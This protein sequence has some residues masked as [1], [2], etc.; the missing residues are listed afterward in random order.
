ML[1]KFKLHGGHSI[2]YA[3]YMLLPRKH[4]RNISSLSRHYSCN[5]GT[6]AYVSVMLCHTRFFGGWFYSAGDI[7]L[8]FVAFPLTWYKHNR[9]KMKKLNGDALPRNEIWLSRFSPD[10]GEK[11][12]NNADN[13]KQTAGLLLVLIHKRVFS[14]SITLLPLRTFPK[15]WWHTHPIPHHESSD[16]CIPGLPI[17]AGVD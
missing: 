13:E 8:H 3:K 15:C 6:A 9:D 10:V 7:L 14:P 2:S 12:R 11:T 4:L 17:K 5:I 1:L 16:S